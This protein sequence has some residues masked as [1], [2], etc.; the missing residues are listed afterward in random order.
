MVDSHA[1][2]RNKREPSTLHP[3]SHSSD[4]SY[5]TTVQCHIQETDIDTI[6]PIIQILSVF[7][8]FICVVCVYLRVFLMQFY[9]ICRFL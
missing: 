9:N 8:A 5:M 2:V 4:K 3:V 6:H 1:V 7:H